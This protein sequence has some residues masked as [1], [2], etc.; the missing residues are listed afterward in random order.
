MNLTRGEAMQQ[1]NPH[2]RGSRSAYT[3]KNKGIMIPTTATIKPGVRRFR[4][5]C[6]D[7]RTANTNNRIRLSKGFLEKILSPSF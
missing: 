6:E 4:L 5:N 3:Y 1:A 7:I 2:L